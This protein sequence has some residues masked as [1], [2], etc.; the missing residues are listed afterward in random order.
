MIYRKW[1][2]E[3][4]ARPPQQ[5]GFVNPFGR[6]VAR[7]RFKRLSGGNWPMLVFLVTKNG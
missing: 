1:G 5:P 3:S 4:V 7:G 2:V 6:R